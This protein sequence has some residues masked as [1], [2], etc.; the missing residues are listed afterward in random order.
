MKTNSINSN[1]MRSFPGIIILFSSCLIFCFSQAGSQN[2]LIN[3]FM[4][5]NTKTIKDKE[6]DYDDWVEIFNA[7]RS[8][9]NMAGMYF[10]NDLKEPT[11]WKI[12]ETDPALTTVKPNDFLIFWF[13][14]DTADGPLHIN[15]KLDK[16]GEKIVLSAYDRKTIIDK[17]KFDP[18]YK[19]ISYGRIPDGS[20]NWNYM[21]KPSPGKSCQKKGIVKGISPDPVFSH[22]GNFY[23]DKITLSMSSPVK[24]AGIYY[25]TDGSDPGGSESTLYT[26]PVNL[27]S[28]TVIKA[29]VLAVDHFPGKII[30]KTYFINDSSCLPV[31]SISIDP[32]HLYDKK[33]G[34]LINPRDKN[35]KPAWFEYY[36]SD[37]IKCLCSGIGIRTAGNVSLSLPKKSFSLHAKNKYGNSRLQYKFF[38]NKPVESFNSLH[39]RTGNIVSLLKNALICEINQ[40]LDHPVDMQAYMPVILFLNG[41]YRGIYFLMERKGKDF[42]YNNY[43]TKNVDII[44]KLGFVAA[45]DSKDYTELISFIRNN[46]LEEDTVYNILETK[47]DIPNLI[48]FWIYEIYTSKG[49]SYGNIRCWKEK[50]GDSKWRWISYDHDW[51]VGYTDTTLQKHTINE[52][53]EKYIFLGKLMQNENFRYL[54][55]NRL[56]DLLNTVF[57]P[58]NMKDIIR[59]VENGLGNEV[60]K[61]LL[62]WNLHKF[63]ESLILRNYDLS[64]DNLKEFT[65]KRHGIIRDHIIERFQLKGMYDLTLN[66]NSEKGGSVSVNTIKIKTFPWTGI[67]FTGVPVS[68]RAVPDEGWKFAGWSDKDLPRGPEIVLDLNKNYELTVIFRKKKD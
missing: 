63:D 45:G 28:T 9:V 25:T 35:T 13:D 6:G 64:I 47:I 66:I 19:D 59:R 16:K 49:D 43:G 57:L 67:Y 18:Q 62:R 32:K 23:R 61:D 33:T 50:T 7:G 21:N 3:E 38:D 36:N 10:S 56:A 29:R 8:P 20:D 26:S 37:R 5:D 2:I 51:W 31:V 22:T 17:V 15:L 68:A 58:Q 42:I 24:D 54:F 52:K 60:K 12:P 41:E 27:D 34:I 46:D 14:K 55:I 53:V 30:T 39:L 65:D 1:I 11:K 40:S 44:E 4:A 48:D